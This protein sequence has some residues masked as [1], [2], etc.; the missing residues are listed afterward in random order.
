[1]IFVHEAGV[2]FVLVTVTLWLQ[3]GGIAVLIAGVRHVTK[4]EIHKSGLFRSASLVVRFTT[5][6]VGLQ[7]LQILLWASCYRWVCLLSWESAVYFSAS[8]Y[9]T[10]GYGDVTLPLKWRMLGPLEGV[11]GVLMCGISV[12]LL[13]G[14]ATRLVGPQRRLS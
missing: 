11:M 7:A 2:A 5:A 8:S 12:S 3:A 14:I 9:A 4:N 13:L 1:M 10:V 6:L